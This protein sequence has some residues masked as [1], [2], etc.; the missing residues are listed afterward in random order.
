MSSNEETKGIRAAFILEVL[1]KPP[2]YLTE[3]LKKIEEELGK[4]KGVKVRESK[5]NEPVE[6]EKQKGFYSSFA[7]IEFEAADISILSLLMFKYMPAHIEVIS[8]ELI[9]LTNNGW[10][11]LLTELTRRLHSYDEVA[12][13]IQTEKILLEKKLKEV[14]ENK[15]PQENSENNTGKI[16][17]KEKS[18]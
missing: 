10:G 2:E 15:E 13:V 6:L 3:T 8:P 7:E 4:E 14:L 9:A 5:I 12:R 1:G 16:S 11:D 17:N 18:K